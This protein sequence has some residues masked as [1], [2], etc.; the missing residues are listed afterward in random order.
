MTFGELIVGTLERASSG[1]KKAIEIL[2][3]PEE[4][5]LLE[6]SIED[7]QIEID[8]LEKD[9]ETIKKMEAKDAWV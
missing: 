9:I 6:Y 7:L 3:R 5:H 1:I 2:K 4:R 8:F